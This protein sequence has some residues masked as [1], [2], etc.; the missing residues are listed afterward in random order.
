MRDPKDLPKNPKK[1][2]APPAVV[3]REQLE[4]VASVCGGVGKAS[5]AVCPTG[6]INS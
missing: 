3:Y 6:P 2:Y 4:A 1:P 5:L